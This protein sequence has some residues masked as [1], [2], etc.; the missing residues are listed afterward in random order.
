MTTLPPLALITVV[1]LGSCSEDTVAVRAGVPR[2]D[3][4]AALPMWRFHLPSGEGC[5]WARGDAGAVRDI[6]GDG[7]WRVYD[8]A[9]PVDPPAVR[10][11]V[12][13]EQARAARCGARARREALVVASVDTSLAALLEAVARLRSAGVAR[14]WL[15]VDDATPERP[16]GG[17]P[18][19]QRGEPL[20][21]IAGGAAWTAMLPRSD[22]AGITPTPEEV[23]R[24]VA[25]A[26]GEG[27]I[28]CAVVAGPGSA[29]LGSILTGVD[30]AAAAGLSQVALV[31]TGDDDPSVPSAA[32][33]FTS[34][35]LTVHDTVAALPVWPLAW[36]G[37]APPG[38]WSGRVCVM[39]DGSS[40]ASP[41]RGAGR[42][43][44]AVARILGAA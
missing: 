33:A 13:E 10:A 14:P 30:A 35:E 11:S 31:V 32:P 4:A 29:T 27:T 18:F 15:L 24:L 3:A 37:D 21:L 38:F 39:D 8:V 42:W 20:F 5:A 23:K 22:V 17:P 16:A 43:D 25:G 41:G 19:F 28:G 40:T 34:R 2:S 7:R 36:H 9:S 12:N 1:A 6:R 44:R 26:T